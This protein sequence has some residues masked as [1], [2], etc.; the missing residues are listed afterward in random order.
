MF[1]KFLNAVTRPAQQ[2]A[3]GAGKQI[4]REFQRE[5]DRA[6]ARLAGRATKEASRRIVGLFAAITPAPEGETASAYYARTGQLRED[7]WGGGDV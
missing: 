2:I 4:E 7:D 1:A 3:E 5:A 6:A